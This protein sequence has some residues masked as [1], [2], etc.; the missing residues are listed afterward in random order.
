MES[1]RA[2]LPPDCASGADAD[3]DGHL[4]PACGGDDC[5]DT[6]PDRFPGNAEICDEEGRDEDC[7]P[8]SVGFRDADGDGWADAACCNADA[9]GG[10]ACGADCDDADPGVNPGAP[11]RC[12]G[13]DDDCDGEVDEGVL[14]R[15][16]VDADGDGHGDAAPGAETR[17]ACVRPDLFARRPDDCDDAD[18]AVHPGAVEVCD[19]GGRDEDCDGVANPDA[20]CVCTDGE[21]IPCLALG[22]CALGTQVCAGGEWTACSVAP[23]PETCD[24]TDE[25]C[26]GLIDEGLLRRCFADPDG[27]GYAAAT[28][29]ETEVCGVGCPPGTTERLP[30]GGEIDCAP[31]DARAFPGQTAYFELPRCAVPCTTPMGRPGC[32]SGT[33]CAA[34]P[35]L[36]DYDCDGEGLPPPPATACGGSCGDCSGG[37]YLYT[38]VRT[39]CGQTVTERT[40]GCAAA[41]CEETLS[42][43][44]L[45]CR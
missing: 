3:G 20:L 23:V 41:A 13:V 26:D 16:V 14:P 42:E 8:A 38:P 1:R 9:A 34:N 4:R 43:A 15:W 7:D 29:A 33:F 32:M 21:T 27:D 11:E 44:V 31:D 22:A 25:D 5:D 37:G 30:V 17:E 40:C 2:C 36:Y 24:G 18:P 28:A 19:D 12:N 45:P 10:R 6:D 39:L 35:S